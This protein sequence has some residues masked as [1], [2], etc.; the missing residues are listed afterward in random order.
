[1]DNGLNYCSLAALA[2]VAALQFC[3][4]PYTQILRVWMQ[5]RNPVFS[6]PLRV[7]SFWYTPSRWPVLPASLALDAYARLSRQH[8]GYG[9]IPPISRCGMRTPYYGYGAIP[10]IFAVRYAYPIIHS[11]SAECS[12]CSQSSIGD[13]G[14]LAFSSRATSV[15]LSCARNPRT[16]PHS[17]LQCALASLGRHR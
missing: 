12:V 13:C 9:A 3:I 5:K 15:L 1:M 8:Y 17:A 16:C 14:M 11:T 10:P 7:R 4:H 2:R 6:V